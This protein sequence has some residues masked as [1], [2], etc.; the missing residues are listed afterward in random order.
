MAWAKPDRRLLKKNVHLYIMFLPIIVY[1]I[2]FKYAPLGGL[3]IAFKDY[4]LYDGIWS[5]PWAGLEHFQRLFSNPQ[6]LNIIRNTLV[7]SVLNIVVGFPFPIIVAILLNEVRKRWFL[8]SVQTLVYLPHFLNWVI[9]GGIV[10]TIFALERGIVNKLLG[11]LFDYSFPF[12][13]NEL[14]WITIY[15][16]AGVWK[17][18]GWGAIIYLAALTSIDQH[19]YEAANLDGANKFRQ[20]WH[21]TLPCIRPTIVL[22]FILNIGNIMEV[23]FDQVWVLKNSVVS[24]VSEVIST[25]SYQ[26][27]LRGGQF[28][29]ATAMGL[30]ESLVGLLLVVTA[31]RVARHFGQ[32]LW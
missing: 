22:L 10:V 3:I 16:F 28:S 13:Y 6:T 19:L 25:Y 31:N 7:L 12:L 14:S 2:V 29:M 24:N 32:G 21:I 18:A 11:T 1:Y 15:V 17:G 20:I 30:F 4:N 26:T 8:R 23:G 5:S 27:G 9:V